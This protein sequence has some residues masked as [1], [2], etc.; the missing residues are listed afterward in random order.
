MSQGLYIQHNWLSGHKPLSHELQQK[1][2]SPS[3]TRL[4]RFTRKEGP[5]D[6]NDLE[7]LTLGGLKG[8]MKF[9]VTCTPRGSETKGEEYSQSLW[10]FRHSI[11]TVKV[12]RNGTVCQKQ[13]KKQKT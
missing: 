11:S 13:T 1:K 8:T 3:A 2:K 5:G 12:E 9:L 4:K 7:T 10:Q 6:A